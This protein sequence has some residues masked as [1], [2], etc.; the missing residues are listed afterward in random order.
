VR[1]EMNAVAGRM[2]IQVISRRM[3]IFTGKERLD[4]FMD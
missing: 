2:G 1:R 3:A 4:T